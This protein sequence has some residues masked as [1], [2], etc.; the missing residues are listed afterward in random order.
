MRTETLNGETFQTLVCG[1]T[2]NLQANAS[3]VNDLNVFPIPDGDTGENMSLTMNG[4]IRRLQEYGG[5]DLSEAAD[6][7]ANGM[8][9][10]ARGNSGVILSQLFAGLSAGLKGKQEATVSEFGEAMREGVRYAYRAVATPTEGTVLTV[11]REA[12]EFAVSRITEN[13]TFSGFGADYMKELQA[14]LKRTPD[15]LPVLKEA[16]VVDSGGAGLYYITDGMLR[17][18]KGESIQQAGT[19][20]SMTTPT[21]TA[22][23]DENSTMEFGYC[24]EFLLQLLRSK[25]D[26]EAFDLNQLIDYL[27]S[28]GDSVVAFRTGTVVKVHVHTMSPGEVLNYGQKYGEF[29][30]LKIENM[31][32]QHHETVIQNRFEPNRNQERKAFALVT[33]AT[34]EGIQKTFRDFGADYIISGGQSSNPST[35]DFLAAFDAVNADVIFVLPNNGN[36]LLTAK[37]AAELYPDSDVRIAESKTIGEGYAALTMLSYDSNDPDEILNTLNEAMQGVVT[38]EITE[39]VRDANLNGIEIRE[40]D[41]IGFTQKTMLAASSSRTETALQLLER[42]NAEQHEAL[43]ILYGNRFPEEETDLLRGKISERFPRTE[44]YEIDGGQ[45]VY[46]LIL[47]LE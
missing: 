43:I 24:T 16:G 2:A 4:G 31:T 5:N 18:A 8:L 30:T 41:Y 42:L 25:C 10:S 44:C 39:A 29:L 23:F 36:I 12:C 27:N 34:G 19:A 20:M 21:E 26:P 15:L 46:D 14:S 28:I 45:D 40:H 38:G 3:I 7:F 33:V 1:G 17:T 6:R 22:S 11:A 13:S 47:I 37:Q 32:L 9:L 35:E